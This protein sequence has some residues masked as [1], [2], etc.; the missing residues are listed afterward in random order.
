M[1][2]FCSNNSVVQ[3]VCPFRFKGFFEIIVHCSYSSSSLNPLQTISPSS[4]TN[5][6]AFVNC[7]TLKLQWNKFVSHFVFNPF[8]ILWLLCYFVKWEEC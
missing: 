3:Y 4:K 7:A 8:Y 1:H 2:S 5:S 6:L